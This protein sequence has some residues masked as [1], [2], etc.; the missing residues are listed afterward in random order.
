MQL[1]QEAVL[2][3]Q[4]G[5]EIVELRDAQRGRLAHVRVLVAQALVEGVAEVVDDLFGAQAAHGPDREGAYERVR[6]VRVLDEGVDSEDDELG[7]RLR[8]VHEV[9]VYELLLLEVDCLHVL[10]DIGE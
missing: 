10:E 6:V 8:V 4:L 1:L 7:L 3:H 5:L 2:Q 9:E